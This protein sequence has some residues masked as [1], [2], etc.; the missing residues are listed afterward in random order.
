VSDPATQRMA[1][2]VSG[3]LRPG[4][5]LREVLDVD[6]PGLLALVG[7][8]YDEYACGPMDPGGF[9][10]DLQL[11]ASAAAE[12]RRRWWVVT[13]G[14]L[15][16]GMVL[17]SVALGPLHPSPDGAAAMELHRLYLAPEVR[18]A[19]LATALVGGVAEEAR[20]AGAARLEAWSDTR[21]VDAHRRY[22]A[23]GF[24]LADGERE[25]HDPAGTT[26]LLFTLEL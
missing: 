14:H 4:L 15:G 17:A 16:P 25:L 1:E 21:L 8:A 26:E 22:L 23:L 6:G 9:D 7:A 2:R 19:G 5:S 10:A 24:T 18:G 3:S 20:L 12:R 13:D 11:P